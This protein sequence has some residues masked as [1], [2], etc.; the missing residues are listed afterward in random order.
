MNISM[1]GWISQMKGWI[2][3][4]KGWIS[5]MKGWIYQMKGWS[6]SHWKGEY[7]TAKMDISMNETEWKKW[8]IYNW[9]MIKDECKMDINILLLNIYIQTHESC[10]FY[11][12]I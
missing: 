7:L 5:K 4:T 2:S 10:P 6:I 3:Q 8:T 1:I 9:K 11:Y 12:H